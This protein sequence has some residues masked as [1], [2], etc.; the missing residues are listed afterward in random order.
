M[1]SISCV[2]LLVAAGLALSASECSEIKEPSSSATSSGGTIT[3]V[4][5]PN[6]LLP[7]TTFVAH[8]KKRTSFGSRLGVKTVTEQIFNQ[9]IQCWNPS[10][11]PNSKLDTVYTFGEAPLEGEVTVYRLLNENSASSESE[12]MQVHVTPGSKGSKISIYRVNPKVKLSRNL[13]KDIKRW[14]AGKNDC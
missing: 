6:A 9:S 7:K 4:V 2:S 12:V 3:T 10:V 13:V 8:V 11:L 5:T 1:K 14:S